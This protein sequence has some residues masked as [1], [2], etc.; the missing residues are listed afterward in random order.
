MIRRWILWLLII[1]FVWILVSRHTEIEKLADTLAQ[2]QWQ[3]V[4]LAILLQIVYYIV[5]AGLYQS[6]FYLVE[7]RRGLFSL[8]PVLFGSLFINVIAPTA[9]TAGTALF[10]DDAA[11]HGQSPARTAAGALLVLITELTAFVLVLV[12]GM[13]YLFRQHDLQTYE[14][15]GA[16]LLMLLI[17]SLSAVLLLGLWWPDLLRRL[18]T[19]AESVTNRVKRLLRPRSEPTHLAAHSAAEFTEAAGAIR[20]HPRRLIPV[21][22]IALTLH[23]IDIACLYTL[24]LAFRQPV[25]L[26]PL[27]AGYS[28]AILFWV[29]SITPQGI[30]V[31]EGVMAL[32]YTSLGIPSARATIIALAFRG[33]AFWLP[34]LIGFIVIRRTKSFRLEERSRMAVVGVHVAAILTAILGV[35]DVL[36]AVLPAL[37]YRIVVLREYLPVGARQGARLATVFVGFL[38]LALAGNLWRRKRVAW[39]IVIVLL[40]IS[41]VT[42]LLKGL[43]FEEASLATGMIIWLWHLRH[44]FGARSDRPSAWQGLRALVAALLFTLAY[45]TAGFYFLDR[46]FTVSF[47]L[48]AALRQTLVMFTQFYD[49]HLQPITGFGREFADSIYVVAAMTFAYALIM[50]MRPVLIRRLATEKERARAKRIVEK[51]GHSSIARFALFDD[52]S[53]YVSPVGSCVAYAV[54]GRVAVAL[55][56]P[57]GPP[58]DAAVTIAAFQGYCS[59]NDWLPAFYQTLPDYLEIYRAV[60]LSTL[61][62]GNEAIVDLAAF[63]LEGKAG[64]DL[65][66]GVNRLTRTGHSY[67]MHEPPLPDSLLDELRIVSDEWLESMHGSEKRFSLGWFDDDYIRSSPVMAI[68]AEDGTVVAFANVI[69][70]YKINETTIDLMRHRRKTESGTMDYLFVALFQWAKEQGYTGFNLGLSPLAGVGESH[71]NPAIEKALHYIFEHVGQFYNFKGLYD[72][73]S[74]FQPEWSPRYLIYPGPAS[75]PAVAMAVIRA[76]SGDGVFWAHTKSLFGK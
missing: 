2:G 22:G 54:R 43:D 47:N 62:I 74:K 28:M 18:L 17:A 31:V 7:V 46:H 5:Y 75:L 9:G 4:L 59:G 10:I 53:Y 42:H 64:K 19:W 35:V 68:H 14:I 69:P 44:Y 8:L 66:A 16:V 27:V 23:V 30:G 39:L 71:E 76:D 41:A 37:N 73:K 49:P 24:F 40:G 21:F 34:L 13:A 38:L 57:I 60:G 52:K 32:V 36:S 70:E 6:A 61:H 72:F 29:V 65:R 3:W 51:W 12:V 63:T 48:I 20:Q 45:G 58:K 1:G 15:V 55:G 11:R 50:I 56:D 33:L 67:Q 25:M 26:G